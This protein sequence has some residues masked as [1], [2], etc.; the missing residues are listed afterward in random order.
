MKRVNFPAL[1]GADAFSTCILSIG[2]KNLPY[3]NRLLSV[4]HIVNREWVIFNER[5][6]PMHF[7]LFNPCP[8]PLDQYKVA[9]NATKGDFKLL[10]TRYMVKGR[11]DARKIYDKLRASSHGLC[12]L[13]G[14]NQATTLDHYLPKAHYPIL[15]VYPWNLVPACKD[16]NTGKSD[17][18][19]KS[20]SDLPLYPYGDDLKFY[21]SDWIEATI[22]SKYGILNFHFFPR[23]PD[24]WL[25]VEKRRALIHFSSYDLESKYKLNAAQF[26]T[27]IVLN[28][29]TLLKSGDADEVIEYYSS[30]ANEVP[31]NST[32]RA[33]YKAI[34][35][36]SDVCN[37]RF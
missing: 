5:K 31:P 23:P 24:R 16:C 14:I 22:T 34:A 19:F 6:N 3:K 13:C 37:G 12:P 29:R 10:Y 9:G 11:R 20:A 26:V 25:D 28:I 36:N 27:S 35:E 32:L 4:A 1:G 21:K 17:P 7:H 2:D 18:V 8:S 30:M 33:M 15:S